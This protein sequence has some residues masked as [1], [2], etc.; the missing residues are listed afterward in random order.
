MATLSRFGVSIPGD[1]IK[2]FDTYIRQR[3]YSN[4]SEAI[5]DLIR[6]KLVAQ[7]WQSAQDSAGVITMV[8]D[9]HQ[10]DLVNRLT[11]IQHDYYTVII[12]SQHIHFDHHNC[13]ETVVVKGD[14]KKIRKLADLLQAT[15]GV[16][17]CNIAMATTGKDLV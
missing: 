13:M 11:D 14:P 2:R 17:Y 12:S 10:R 8:F 15:R 4:R 9:H 16:K 7:D 5:R 3:G 6:D 1:L